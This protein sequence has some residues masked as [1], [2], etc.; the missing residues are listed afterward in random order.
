M[1]QE[2]P[3]KPNLFVGA[4]KKAVH[5]LKEKD[6][7]SEQATRGDK[8]YLRLSVVLR[9]TRSGD[10]SFARH[11]AHRTQ[12]CRTKHAISS[13]SLCNLTPSTKPTRRKIFP[14]RLDFTENTPRERRR[15]QTAR[16]IFV[17][18]HLSMDPHNRRGSAS[19]ST[20]LEDQPSY[21]GRNDRDL[22]LSNPAFLS[23]GVS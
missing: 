18:L 7:K 3:S 13:F 2:N 5:R 15:G 21:E 16:Q 9:N 11:E 20:F 23:G 22:L 12:S 14:R 17:N 8:M 4:G 10:S 6:E 19:F 1:H